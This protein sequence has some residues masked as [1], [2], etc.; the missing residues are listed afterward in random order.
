MRLAVFSDLHLGIKQNDEGWQL[1]ALQW[2]DWFV[3]ELRKNNIN[4]IVFLGDFFHSRTT[5]SVDTLYTTALVLDKLNDFN[6]H[7]IY[8]NHDLYY[9]NNN[10]VSAV[11]LFKYYPNVHVYD[12]P[13][14]VEF[15]DKKCC[16]C[17]WGYDPLKFNA[18]IL[19]THA[20]INA[21]KLGERQSECDNGILCSDLLKNY[22]LVY[23]GHFHL[24]QTKSYAAGKIKYVGNP[25]QMDYSD[26]GTCK[27]F[28]I[29]DTDTGEIKFIENTIS[30]TFLRMQLSEM[31]DFIDINELK[32]KLK[33]SFFKLLVDLNIKLEDL[34]ELMVLINSAEPKTSVFEWENGQ[35]FSQDVT[36]YKIEAINLED[37]IKQFINLLDIPNKEDIFEY[38]ISLYKKVEA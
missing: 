19:F 12:K 18:D 36:E 22:S 30:P 27:G 34:K 23:S 35:N 38:I 28:D 14:I 1:I 26:E 33:N 7:M 13:K 25:F 17:G 15:G 3:N 2:C 32:S 16:M 21:F 8:G 10:I 20:E 24:R 5:I 4:D 37:C 29:Y 11:S 6:I 9:L 31:T